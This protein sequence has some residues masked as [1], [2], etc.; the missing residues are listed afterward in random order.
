VLAVLALAAPATAAEVVVDE[1]GFTPS[2]TVVSLGEEVE[3]RNDGTAVHGTRHDANR[4]LW[5]KA[6]LAPGE[7][8]AFRFLRPGT[9]EYFDPTNPTATATIVV[10]V[11]GAGRIRVPRPPRGAA[12][13]EYRV[14]VIVTAREQVTVVDPTGCESGRVERTV[15][16]RGTTSLQY[17]RF[18]GVGEAAVSV[19]GSSGRFTLYRSTEDASW[20]EA[21][22]Q[23]CPETGGAPVDHECALDATGR[24]VRPS[25]A[26]DPQ[27]NRIV[28]VN[29]GPDVPAGVP[30]PDHPA[31]GLHHPDWCGIS[32]VN[33]GELTPEG[34]PL[35][36]TGGQA[37]FDTFE[38]EAT[39]AELTR[40]R[41]GR[42]VTVVRELRINSYVDCCAG[43]TFAAV[44]AR[45]LVAAKVEVRL[46]PR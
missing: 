39:P 27:R 15:R 9:Y 34:A 5:D 23:K 46:R 4:P 35:S 30:T 44:G 11:R 21:D 3:W 10:R 33:V 45:F 26:W 43:N 31:H 32:H 6:D 17:T 41:Q 24:G 16:W 13:H 25:L 37:P 12:T 7:T 22:D 38:A 42:P 1:T 28:V 2:L 20:L 19:S 40:L 18:P 29:R 36:F 8:F 14:T